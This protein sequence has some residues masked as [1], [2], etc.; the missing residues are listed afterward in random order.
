MSESKTETMPWPEC[1]RSF[2]R[3]C[4]GD[5]V[6][7][8]STRRQS[9]RRRIPAAMCFT[10]RGA[11]GDKGPGGGYIG[12]HGRRQLLG[13]AARVAWQRDDESPRRK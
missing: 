5:N 4:L 13:D 6:K 10:P 3:I 12:V 8:L 2:V 7:R 9:E 1:V 11:L